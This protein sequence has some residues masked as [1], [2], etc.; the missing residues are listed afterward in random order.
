MT[1][2]VTIRAVAEEAGVSISTVSNVASGRHHQMKPE[3]RERVLAAME[4]LR[5]R[6]NQVARSL[7]TSRTSTIGLVMGDLT[8]SLYPPVTIGAEAACREAGYSL[9]L[10]SADTPEAERKAIDVMRS[11]QVDAVI[12]FSIAFLEAEHEFLVQADREGTA[13]VTLNRN[14]PGDAPL[15]SVWFD[16]RSGGWLATRHLIEL[17]HERIAHIGG[18]ENRLTGVQRRRGYQ[19]AL[20]HAGFEVSPSLWREGDHSFESGERL[21]LELWRERPTAVFVGGDTMA[22]GAL[23]A[24]RKLDLQVPGDVSLIAFG[25]PDAVRFAT[26]ALT[27]IDLPVAEAGRTAVELALSRIRE[28][29]RKEVRT[30][31]PALLV[32]ETT[33]PPG[34]AI[35]AA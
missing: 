14:L 34:G 28:P 22:L 24:L 6:P 11:N 12:L 29:Q 17:G 20:E 3:T 15:S 9:L 32:R 33:A 19:D 26:P 8:N 30:L 27:T 10:A 23:R 18:P 5:Y 35:Q 1:R 16:H 2:R 25:N 21:M 13:I 31:Q 7:V 4:K